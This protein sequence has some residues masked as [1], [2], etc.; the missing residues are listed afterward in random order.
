MSTLMQASRQWATRPEE[1]RF[2]SLD[3]MAAHFHAQRAISRAAVVSSR[4]LRAVPDGADGLLA[5]MTNSYFITGAVTYVPGT[6][7]AL[8]LNSAVLLAPDGTLVSQYDKLHL[9]PFGEYQPRGLP[10]Q[11]VPGGGFASGPGRRTLDLPGIPAVGPLVCYEVIFPGEVTEPGHRPAWLLNVTNDAWY[12]DSA[13]PRQHLASARMR[14]VEEG[15]PLA[16]DA[17]TGSERA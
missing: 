1:E 15:L 8:A 16:R 12:G 14:A 3:A 13:G 9:V 7:R 5:R 10:I 17:N 11:I 6:E 2:T 4:H